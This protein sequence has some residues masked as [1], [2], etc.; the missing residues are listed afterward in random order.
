ME[1][2]E[3]G[4]REGGRDRGSEGGTEGGLVSGWAGECERYF[5]NHKCLVSILVRIQTGIIM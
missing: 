5:M 2:R 1:E 3:G 4:R